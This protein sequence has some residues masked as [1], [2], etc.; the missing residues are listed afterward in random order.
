MA[1]FVF[2]FLS[3]GTAEPPSDEVLLGQSP[4]WPKQRHMR[5]G[6]R[7]SCYDKKYNIRASPR[8][9]SAATLP[10]KKRPQ[11]GCPEATFQSVSEVSAYVQKS[12]P[13]ESE[14]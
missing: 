2:G 14:F 5:S 1:V 9:S 13:G 8:C 4:S 12:G 3:F 7:T 10:E 11:E 6:V